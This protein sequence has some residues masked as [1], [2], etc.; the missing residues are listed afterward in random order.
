[1]YQMWDCRDEKT[2][3][4]PDLLGLTVQ[5]QIEVS[6]WA[7]TLQHKNFYNKGKVWVSMTAHRRA[8]NSF[9][10]FRKGLLEEI[11]SKW[12]REE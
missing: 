12:G 5:G 2:Y 8:Q 6:K 7:V 9:W 11:P 3:S 1:M 10:G 4:Y